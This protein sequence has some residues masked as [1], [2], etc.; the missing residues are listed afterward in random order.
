MHR[1]VLYTKNAKGRYEV[2]KEPKAEDPNVYKRVGNKYVPIGIKTEDNWL[3][4]GLWLVRHKGR[5]GMSPD[6]YASKW[7]LTKVAEVPI[8]DV[9]RI[10]AA[11]DIREVIDKYLYERFGYVCEGVPHQDIAD[12]L[13][14]E[15][16]QIGK[17]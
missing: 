9:S 4:D 17:G 13:T 5:S 6:C 16:M 1:P 10:A 8:T 3:T 2:Y 15:I 7:G 12:E 11:A 14:K